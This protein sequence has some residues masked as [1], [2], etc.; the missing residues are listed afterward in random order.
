MSRFKLSD[1]TI[2]MPGQGFVFGGVQ[3][4]ADWNLLTDEQK[5]A[6]GLVEI[7]YDPRPDDRFY[8]VNEDPANPGKWQATPKN[9]SQVKAMMAAQVNAYVSSTLGQTD[10]MHARALDDAA[11]VVPADVIAHR[12]AV[13]TQGRALVAEIVGITDFA[14]LA[15]WQAH[16]WPAEANQLV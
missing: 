9:M 10:W 14:E 2:V 6:I 13:R 5:A 16:D 3:Y 15:A 1:N 11:L 12:N 7:I 8:F 4:G